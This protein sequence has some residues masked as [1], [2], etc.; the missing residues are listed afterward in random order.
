MERMSFPARW[1]DDVIKWEHFPHYWPFAR[2]THRSAVN[3]PLKN[4]WALMFSLICA[5][6]KGW[7]N[8]RNAVDLRC[9][10]AHYNVTVMELSDLSPYPDILSGRDRYYVIC[11]DY[12][13]VGNIVRYCYDYVGDRHPRVVHCV[14]RWIGN[15]VN[16]YISNF[17][18]ITSNLQR[19]LWKIPSVMHTKHKL[20]QDQV[21][22]LCRCT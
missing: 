13:C 18:H 19:L 12:E 3:S 20:G 22:L 15:F 5:W 17:I 4:Q 16:N 2:G 6:R 8:N 10:R 11:I 9:H 14:W 7:V 1:H 21:M